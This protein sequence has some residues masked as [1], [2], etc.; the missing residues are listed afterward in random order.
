MTEYGSP[1]PGGWPAGQAPQPSHEYTAPPDYRPTTAF[2][3]KTVNPLD[4]AIMAGAVLAL[5]FS[6]FS[7]YQYKPKGPEAEQVCK[8]VTG[9]PTIHDICNGVDNSAWHGFFGW[10]GVLLLLV[11]AVVVAVALFAPQV[12][13][14]APARMIALVLAAL[15]FVFV[16][17]ALFVVPDGV[18]QGRTI[19]AGSSD[20]DAG[21][22]FSYWVVLVLAA[23]VT[24]LSALRLVQA[25]G[26]TGAGTDGGVGSGAGTQPPVV[27]PQ[28]PG[29]Q[30]PGYQQP[31]YQ[32]PGYQQQPPPPPPQQPGYQQPGYQQQPPPA[33][34]QQPGYAAPPPP[35]QAPPQDAPQAAQAPAAP[36]APEPSQPQPSPPPAPPSS[37]AE[38]L[39]EPSAGAPPEQPPP[40]YTPPPQ[41]EPRQE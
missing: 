16:L 33:P 20:V 19:P 29:Y 12:T 2:D 4:W 11:A 18:Y 15:G 41:Q 40:G 23:L 6:F 3:P 26:E 39:P 34:P 21:H 37:P 8:T 14:P 24:A 17:I 32:Q 10:F 35:A 22:G 13:L 31:G 1:P 5:I 25:S 30:Q 9:V 27:P 38:A 28:Q 36:A 7:F